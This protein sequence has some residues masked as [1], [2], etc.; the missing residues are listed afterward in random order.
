[1]DRSSIASF[2]KRLLRQGRALLRR[3]AGLP[4]GLG[5]DQSE[6]HYIHAA[7]E[8]IELGRYGRCEGCGG[9]VESARLEQAPWEPCCGRCAI[10]HGAIAPALA[11]T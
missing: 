4:L 9:G 7:L 8:R 5:E 1:M 6:L 3:S 11:S 2:R 10:S